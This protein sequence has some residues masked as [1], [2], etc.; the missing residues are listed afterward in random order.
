[1]LSRQSSVMFNFARNGILNI[2]YAVSRLVP[3]KRVALIVLTARHESADFIQEL[4]TGLIK[5]H[6]C[7]LHANASR[8]LI[9]MSKNLLDSRLNP[10]ITIFTDVN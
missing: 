1:V 9:D 10:L 5:L 2:M 7:E 3:S 4:K 8:L 6:G